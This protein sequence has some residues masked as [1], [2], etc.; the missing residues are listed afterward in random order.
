MFPKHEGF[1]SIRET[2]RPKSLLTTDR[3]NALYNVAIHCNSLEGD[4]AE[5]GCHAGGTSYMLASVMKSDK[6]L[7]AFDSFQGL[8]EMTE[9][10]RDAAGNFQLKPK[11]FASD[12]D[13][14][15]KYLSIFGD[16]V[17]V[18][19]GWIADTLVNASDRKFSLVYIDL[20]IYEPTKMAID[21]F[22]SRMVTDSYM[23]FDDY[24][25]GSTIRVTRAVDQKFPNLWATCH[26]FVYPQLGVRHP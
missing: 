7:F 23:V 3:L 17:K 21:F 11:N 2:V 24:K 25:W 18:Y 13:K 8:S 5:V 1:D 22:W 12:R 9:Q 6:K 10:D 15:I 20:D 14:A 26:Y 19:D 4:F 16:R